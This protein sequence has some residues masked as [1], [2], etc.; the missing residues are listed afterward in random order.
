VWGPIKLVLGIPEP[1]TGLQELEEELLPK[2]VSLADYRNLHGVLTALER[3]GLA[4]AARYLLI[5][6]WKAVKR[7]VL[8]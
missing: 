2:G 1:V 7:S 6:E 5:R 3:K 4:S 8:V